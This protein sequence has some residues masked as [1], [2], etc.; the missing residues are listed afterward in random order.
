MNRFL[1]F[2]GLIALGLNVR[3]I[4]RAMSTMVDA[5]NLNFWGW[6]PGIYASPFF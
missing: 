2:I 5:L 3:Y 6:Y 4:Y 1:F